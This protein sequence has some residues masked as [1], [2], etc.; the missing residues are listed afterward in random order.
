MGVVSMES[1][2]NKEYFSRT[3]FDSIDWIME[4]FGAALDQAINEA[5]PQ[6]IN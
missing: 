5:L 4:N 1:A 3:D 2:R 6:L